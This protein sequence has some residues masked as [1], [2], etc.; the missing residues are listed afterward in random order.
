[1]KYASVSQSHK[2]HNNWQELSETY[3]T[4]PFRW[5]DGWLTATGTKLNFS[6]GGSRACASFFGHPNAAGITQRP[7]FVVSPDLQIYPVVFKWRSGAIAVVTIN[8]WCHITTITS[9]ITLAVNKTVSCNPHQML[10]YYLQPQ[11][12]CTIFYYST[13]DQMGVGAQHTRILC[14]S[15][16]L[17]CF[18]LTPCWPHP[19]NNVIHIHWSALG[20]NILRQNALS[21][22]LPLDSQDPGFFWVLTSRT[23]CHVR[24]P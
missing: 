18:W 11:P 22:C 13:A 8:K 16:C 19:N 2:P 6:L 3:S 10:M 5:M 12:L 17:Q 23:S 20:G 14:F 21:C 1:M 9:G 15:A 24:S 4:P 7:I